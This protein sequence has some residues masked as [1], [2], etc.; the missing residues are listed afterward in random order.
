MF[1]FSEKV[2]YNLIKLIKGLMKLFCCFTG[3]R[4][5]QLPWN[6][7]EKDPSCI[8]LKQIISDLIDDAADSGISSFYCG[9]ALGF[10][11][12][13]AEEVIRKKDSGIPLKLYAAIPCSDQCS[14]WSAADR[15]RYDAILERCDGRTLISPHYTSTCMLARNRYMVD[16]SSMIISAWNGSFR[17]GT[18][19]TLR[20]GK[21]MNRDIRIIHLPDLSVTVI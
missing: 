2:C 17:G 5:Q 7:N 12:Y 6:T 14:G 1:A 9:M 10:D 13:C 4:P 15:A 21:H 16:N 3:H 8:K 18:G 20:Y 19:Y 11:T